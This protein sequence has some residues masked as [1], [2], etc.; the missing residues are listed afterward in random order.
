MAPYASTASRARLSSRSRQASVNL[1]SLSVITAA[2]TLVPVRTPPSSSSTQT[3]HRSGCYQV[4]EQLIPTFESWPD[5]LAR[6]HFDPVE[7]HLCRSM[8][9]WVCDPR[10]DTPGQADSGPLAGLS[11]CPNP[12]HAKDRRWCRCQSVLVEQCRES[13]WGRRGKFI[14]SSRWTRLASRP[15]RAVGGRTR[16]GREVAPPRRTTRGPFMSLATRST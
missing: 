5:G 11:R 14:V 3:S 8:S 13:S 16:V 4:R 6:W 1:A 7:L 15:G 10:L 12:G 9:R 2:R